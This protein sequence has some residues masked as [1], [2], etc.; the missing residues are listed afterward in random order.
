M[1]LINQMLQDLDARRAA[2]G[3]GVRLPND[4][5]PLPKAPSSNWPLGIA[6]ALVLPQ[7][8][9]P[10][11]GRMAFGVAYLLAAAVLA[12]SVLRLPSAMK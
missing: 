1:S 9:L 3:V 4:V 7:F 6:I 10:P 11:V 12:G 8:Y 5:R 2:H